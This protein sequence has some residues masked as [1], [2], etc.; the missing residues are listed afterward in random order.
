M[1]VKSQAAQGLGNS[2]TMGAAAS[3]AGGGAPSAALA[4]SVN[5]FGSELFDRLAAEVRERA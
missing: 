5:A 3:H 4:A 2:A 1:Q